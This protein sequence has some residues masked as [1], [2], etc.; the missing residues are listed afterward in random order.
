MGHTGGDSGLLDAVRAMLAAEDGAP[1]DALTIR[2]G[3]L[4]PA[5]LAAIEAAAAELVLDVDVVAATEEDMAFDLR[6]GRTSAQIVG[7][8]ARALLELVTTTGEAHATVCLTVAS[9]ER[10][11][12]YALWTDRV[13]SEW[14]DHADSWARV[15]LLEAVDRVA[16]TAILATPGGRAMLTVAVP[17]EQ[18]PR[19]EEFTI[20]VGSA[21]P[22]VVASADL[23]ELPDAA[24]PSAT[25]LRVVD[26]CPEGET[27]ASL[28]RVRVGHRLYVEVAC[29]SCPDRV[30]G[31]AVPASYVP[32]VHESGF[33]FAA[34]TEHG[35]FAILEPSTLRAAHASPDGAVAA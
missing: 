9:D 2:Y 11:T 32:S 20:L 8:S 12:T 29:P 5:H 6:H 26:L 16:G 28:L 35:V 3:Q 31:V 13:T 30:R 14:T 17:H 15:E 19:I 10:A 18:A 34:I 23:E 21:T 25:V 22:V 4:W 33:D 24:E 1:S 7:T 27:A